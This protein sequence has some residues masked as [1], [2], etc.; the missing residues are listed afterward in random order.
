V[1]TVVQ[2]LFTKTHYNNW[3]YKLIFFAKNR[4]STHNAQSNQ[5]R[6]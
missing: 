1:L 4:M 6:R 3:F 5:S 2:R